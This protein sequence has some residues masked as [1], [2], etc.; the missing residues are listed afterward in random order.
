MYANC[1]FLKARSVVF[2]RIKNK[3]VV[4]LN[5]MIANCSKSR[6]EVGA[7][8]LIADTQLEI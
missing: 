2:V 5:A 1:G 4:S 8:R 7:I 6:D 3:N